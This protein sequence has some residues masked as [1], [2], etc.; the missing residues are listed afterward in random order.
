MIR[1]EDEEM[2]D[3]LVCGISA[4]LM[5]CVCSTFPNLAANYLYLFLGV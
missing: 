1:E 2:L 5:D 4:D 3:T